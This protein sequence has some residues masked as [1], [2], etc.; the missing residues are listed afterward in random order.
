MTKLPVVSK[1]T[2]TSIVSEIFA[3]NNDFGIEEFLSNL[4]KDNKQ[5]A[6]VLYTLLD[7]IVDNFTA[8]EYEREHVAA[9]YKI[10]SHLLYKSLEK[11]IE[12]NE[13]ET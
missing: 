3:K 12:I 13:M 10:A 8:D 4:E 5:L 11:Q 9:I 7:T 1:D 2:I 6:F